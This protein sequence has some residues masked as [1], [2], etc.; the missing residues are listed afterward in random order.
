MKIELKEKAEFL[1]IELSEPF[2]YDSFIQFI[3]ALGSKKAEKVL[4]DGTKLEN[5]NLSYKERYDIG[6]TAV[7]H[8]DINLKYVV[9]WAARDIN[10]FAISI[11]R[12]R[13]FNVKVFDNMPTAKKW[14]LNQ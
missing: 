14:L 6:N 12:L 1:K 11:M 8:L 4:I 2:H 9:I 3:V 5:T 13:G 7:G 10:Y